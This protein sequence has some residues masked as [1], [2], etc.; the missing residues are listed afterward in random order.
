MSRSV[1]NAWRDAIRDSE[2]DR[3]AKLVAFVVSTYMGTTGQ[4]WPSKATIA[5]GAGLGAGKRAVDAAVDRLE[6]AGYLRVGRSKGRRP[7]RYFVAVPTWHPDATF[8]NSNV[9]DFDAQR[10]TK[11]RPTSHPGATE[12]YEIAEQR[13]A[14]T[15]VRASLSEKCVR[16]QGAFTTDDPDE[17]YCGECRDKASAASY[18]EAEA[19]Y[20]RRKLSPATEAA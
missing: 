14:R 20:M 9:A 11:R 19:R 15:D 2:L 16:C 1:V 10:R 3:T 6:A 17:A 12:S 4:A 18:S 13:R 7:F 5:Q 8:I